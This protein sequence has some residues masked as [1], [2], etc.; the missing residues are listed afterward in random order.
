MNEINL[1][2]SEIASLWTG[3]MNDS[4]SKC[5]LGFMLQHIEDPDIKSVVQHSYDISSNHIEQLISIF[6][7]EQFAIPNG[8]TEQNV[9]MN[10]PWLFS[11]I[12]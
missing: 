1:T 11:D 2:S 7:S 3:Y 9:N 10:A 8:F 5:I 4:M 12:L 6:E